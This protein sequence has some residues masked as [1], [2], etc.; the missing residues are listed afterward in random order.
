MINYIKGVK[1]V[2][3]FFLTAGAS[4]RGTR[5]VTRRYLY[6]AMM[7]ILL[8]SIMVSG[9]G[10][11]DQEIKDEYVKSAV[12]A[13]YNDVMRN[14]DSFK[15]KVLTFTGEVSFVQENK[16]NVELMVIVGREGVNGL[17]VWVKYTKKANEERILEGDTIKFWGEFEKIQNHKPNSL[18]EFNCPDIHVKY[19]ERQKAVAKAPIQQ[20]VSTQEVK[21]VTTSQTSSAPIWSL[22]GP[23]QWGAMNGNVKVR[24][25]VESQDG[26]VIKGRLEHVEKATASADIVGSFSDDGLLTFNYVDGWY[27][28]GTGTIK[29][30][31]K[32][33][34]VVE[35]VEKEKGKDARMFIIPGKYTLK[36]M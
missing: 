25:Y 11:S 24:L 8:M 21:P 18:I 14:P 30:I 23:S 12:Q 15:G 36:R 29:I 4:I 35:T 9:C 28:K 31:D 6:V 5:E 17:P 33:T 2:T 1:N 26:P 22:V 32:N 20:K 34:L 7:A 19:V 13:D 16:E 10:K 3:N 27:S